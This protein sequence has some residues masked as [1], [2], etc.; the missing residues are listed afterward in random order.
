MRK[1]DLKVFNNTSNYILFFYQNIIHCG[2]VDQLVDRSLRMREVRGS[3][4]RYSSFFFC[5]L[6]LPPQVQLSL[7]MSAWIEAPL[8]QFCA[9][10]KILVSIGIGLDDIHRGSLEGP[11]N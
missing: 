7:Q 6:F 1:S 9:I 3:K 10:D 5:V 2:V 8:L 4:P 11:S